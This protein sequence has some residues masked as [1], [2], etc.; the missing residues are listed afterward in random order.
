MFKTHQPNHNDK[1]H[2]GN[3]IGNNKWKE[4]KREK[5]ISKAPNVP[6]SVVR[7][8]TKKW[9][10]HGKCHSSECNLTF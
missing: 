10:G 4:K 1:K 7:L 8:I 2:P 5:E 3:N 9:K 6:Q